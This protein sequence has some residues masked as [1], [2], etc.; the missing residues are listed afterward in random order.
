M[1]GISFLT[2]TVTKWLC[3]GFAVVAALFGAYSYGNSS[4][5][6][7]GYKEGWDARQAT[8]DTLTKTINDDRK[9]QSDKIKEIEGEVA[10]KVANAIADQAA[11]KTLRLQISTD[12][13]A[14][15]PVVAAKCGWDTVTVEAINAT[16]DTQKIFDDIKI[17][18]MCL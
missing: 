10:D 12:F 1:F 6:A 16:L 2:P 13:V 8:V 15:N 14:N 4:G 5:H 9:A 7:S 3:I 17:W 18:M 11:S